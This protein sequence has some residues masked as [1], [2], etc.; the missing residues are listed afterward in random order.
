MIKTFSII[1]FC[2]LA[3]I[4]FSQ[5]TLYNV[6]IKSDEEIKLRKIQINRDISFK[7]SLESYNYLLNSLNELFN[8]GFLEASFD[9]LLY[10]NNNVYAYLNS[11]KKYTWKN[12]IIREFD[13]TKNSYFQNYTLESKSN[14]I[15]F[16]H[17]EEYIDE[18]LG[19][20]ENSGYPFTRIKIDSISLFN[21]DIEL[22]IRIDKGQLYTVDT[23][24]IASKEKINRKLV[25]QLIEISPGDVY[26]EK[27]LKGINERIKQ[28]NYLS[29]TRPS[30]L[31]F[32]S[33]SV[34]LYMFLKKDKANHFNGILGFQPGRNTDE[35]LILTGDLNLFLVNS[36]NQG[37]KIKL[38]WKK[39]DNYSQYLNMN[40]DYSYLFNTDFGVESYL[41][42]DK[43][44]SSYVNIETIIGFKYTLSFNS[45]ILFF[46]KNKSSIVAQQDNV[47]SNIAGSKSN[48]FGLKVRTSRINDIYNPSKGYELDYEFASGKRVTDNSENEVIQQENVNQFNYYEFSSDMN[49]YTKLFGQ[50][51]GN[52]HLNIGILNNTSIYENE[53]YRLGGY[54]S[55]KGFD[56]RSIYA[57]A[58]SLFNFEIRY[59]YEE[60]SN[61]YIFWNGMYYEKIVINKLAITDFPFG[62]GIGVNFNTKTGIFSLAYA[63]GKQFE[64]SFDIRTAKIHFGFSNQF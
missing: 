12:I 42:L 57:T 36:F 45:E 17:F 25:S 3:T 23:L 4:L 21:N 41:I 13:Q 29:I 15:E 11:G 2:G 5:D 58:Y 56:E 48:L 16:N 44:D 20:Y 28:I 27:K 31:E 38:N 49:L 22:L 60:R 64:N 8:K 19:K 26:N 37:E 14:K 32:N 61:A 50:F 62:F 7:D 34:M 52:I 55:L 53:T 46:Y 40:F 10:S 33:E 9:T 54:N 35:N 18:L 6:F 30:G 63:L 1:L 59:L 47:S 39:F 51:V 43:K 24:I